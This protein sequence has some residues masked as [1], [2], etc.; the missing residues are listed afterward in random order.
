MAHDFLNTRLNL[1]ASSAKF[2]N[3]VNDG[4]GAIGACSDKDRGT[5]R[6]GVN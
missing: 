5:A 1:N 6:I 3:I 2:V 4:P